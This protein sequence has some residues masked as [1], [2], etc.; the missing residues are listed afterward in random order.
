LIPLTK[1]IIS[2]NPK[3]PKLKKMFDDGGLRLYFNNYS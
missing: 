3:T 2:L 1:V